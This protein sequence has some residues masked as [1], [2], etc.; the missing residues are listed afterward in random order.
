[1]PLRSVTGLEVVASLTSEFS[2]SSVDW[3]RCSLVLRTLIGVGDLLKGVGPANVRAINSAKRTKRSADFMR[4]ATNM[5]Q[6]RS[7]W[8]GSEN[9]Q[10]LEFLRQPMAMY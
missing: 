9:V 8:A 7:R 4:R 10:G 3:K 5:A 6:T 2:D 1:M